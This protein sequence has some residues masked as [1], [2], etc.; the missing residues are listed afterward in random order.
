VNWKSS[1]LKLERRVVE[2]ISQTMEYALRAAVY[3]AKVPN[4]P[5]T[6]EQIA[7]A[8]RVPQA[9]LSKI[10]QQLG[11]AGIV[12][13]QR[14]LGGGFRLLKRPEEISLLEVVSAIE[15]LQRFRACASGAVS[16]MSKLCSLHHW[17]DGTLANVEAAFAETT[18]G[19]IVSESKGRVPLC[20][21]P[22][23][24]PAPRS[25]IPGRTLSA[26]R[27]PVATES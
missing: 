2:M 13:G 22:R 21:V 5:R 25:A 20:D 8:T 7:N 14:G 9:Y 17:L 10:M 12:C 1:N 16:P 18:L 3:L 23:T 15:L 6:S 24:S 11:E 4:T 26:E 27:W 19:D